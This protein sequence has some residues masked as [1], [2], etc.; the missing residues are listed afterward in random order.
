MTVAAAQWKKCFAESLGTFAL[1]FTGTGAI[2]I[3]QVSAEAIT[4]VGIAL[5]FSLVVLAVLRHPRAW[6][7]LSRQTDPL[8]L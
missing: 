2:I 3:N 5:T 7:L 6:L 4:H 8:T 1:V